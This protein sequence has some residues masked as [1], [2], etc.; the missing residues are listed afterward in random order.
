MGQLQHGVNG[1]ELLPS[2]ACQHPAVPANGFLSPGVPT[3]SFPWFY[4]LLYHN[5][6]A[7]RTHPSRLTCPDWFP[8]PFSPPCS[9]SSL[10]SWAI[11][12]ESRETLSSLLLMMSLSSSSRRDSRSCSFSSRKPRSS[13][14]SATI[15]CLSTSVCFCKIQ[16]GNPRETDVPRAREGSGKPPSRGTHQQVFALPLPLSLGFFTPF[17]QGA[18][19]L[20]WHLLEGERGDL[21]GILTTWDQEHRAKGWWGIP[22]SSAAKTAQISSTM[23]FLQLENTVNP[24]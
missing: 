10:S 3:P 12:S 23:Y 20:L 21:L 4:T 11:S 18:Q 1:P 24:N 5:L 13:L 22:S 2:G 15:F 17:P 8:G 16:R 19:M 6:W 9:P 14:H 7:G